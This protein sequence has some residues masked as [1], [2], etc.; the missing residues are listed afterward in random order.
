VFEHRH[1]NA[2]RWLRRRQA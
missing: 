2:P 1:A